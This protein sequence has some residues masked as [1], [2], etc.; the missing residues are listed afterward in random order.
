MAEKKNYIIEDEDTELDGESP[1]GE[2]ARAEDE[3]MVLQ[4]E[5]AERERL[6]S[7]L[8]ELQQETEEAEEK[9]SEA[10]EEELVTGVDNPPRMRP[11]RAGVRQSEASP[12]Y[13]FDERNIVSTYGEWAVTHQ[14]M[15]NLQ[16]NIFISSD[17]LRNY[18][19]EHIEQRYP[20]ADANQFRRVYNDAVE[21]HFPSE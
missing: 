7:E 18:T 11:S 21:Y 14:G 6:E 16:Y 8:A 10:E 13:D 20:Y 3:G 5:E 12:A 4:E 17:V 15:A 2:L 19:K 1:D 9:L